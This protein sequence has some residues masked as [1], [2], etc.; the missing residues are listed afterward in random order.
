MFQL[1]QRNFDADFGLNSTT[2]VEYEGSSTKRVWPLLA[3][4]YSYARQ[5]I[6]AW[7]SASKMT[8]IANTFVILSAAPQLPP[9]SVG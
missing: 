4:R 6:E 7:C 2:N 9:F 5:R 1:I 3:K 8:S